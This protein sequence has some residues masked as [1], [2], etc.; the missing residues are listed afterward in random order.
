MDF[1]KEHMDVFA[2]SH[3]DMPDIN[4]SVII[5]RL[6]IDPTYKH[7]IQKH[8]GFNLKQH[9]AISEEVSKLFKAKFI[10]EAHYP[11]WLANVMMVKKANRK[12]RIC[13]NYTNLN[14]AYPK[15][16]FP[17]LRI[18]QLV[19]ATAGH[20]L[21][22]SMDAHFG[23]NHIRM[24]PDDEDKTT[25][26]IYHDLYCYKVISFGLKNAGVTYQRLVNKVFA[27]LIGKTM[28]VYID[29]MMVKNLRKEDHVSD[30]R[31]TFALL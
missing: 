11:E 27:E 20:K 14:K 15:D 25:F 21:L 12:W 7:V 9:T 23:Y 4:L 8:C 6:N 13:I 2:W 1:L 29:G 3:E 31:E 10:R 17:L 22:S 30:L 26:T 19:D 16:S 5:H 18:D 28:E 24:C